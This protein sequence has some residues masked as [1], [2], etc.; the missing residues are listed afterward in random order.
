MPIISPKSYLILILF[1][2]S[3]V[4]KPY[5]EIKAKEPVRFN[6]LFLHFYNK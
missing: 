4:I 2:H 3:N 6:N 5:K 1:L